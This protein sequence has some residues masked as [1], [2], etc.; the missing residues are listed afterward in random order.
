M[1]NADILVS[2][3][4][5]A[6]N[7]AHYIE[8]SIRSVMDQTVKNWELLVIDDCSRDNTAEVIARLAEEDARIRLIKNEQNLGTA[9]TRNKALDMFRGK[10]VAF[11]DSDDLWHTEKLERQLR[12]IEAENADL[13]YTSYC[14][15]HLD[16]KMVKKDYIVPR[17]VSLED[18]L[19]Q[20]YIGCSTVMLT[21]ELAKKYR[22][23]REFYHEDYVFW[24]SMLRNGIKT[25]GIE[26]VLMD[27]SYYSSSRAGNKPAAAK[28]RWNIY[29]R[30]MKF[31]LLKSFWYMAHYTLAGIR[32]YS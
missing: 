29:R 20:N 22:F 25:A 10:Y 14:V 27:Y 31:P 23:T 12:V 9:G 7:A 1:N 13:C 6:Y 32:K 18:M 30:Y 11:L 16:N 2:V 17:S 24:L 26:D 28:R 8:A 19:K 15:V 5:P 4:M 21:S 3:I